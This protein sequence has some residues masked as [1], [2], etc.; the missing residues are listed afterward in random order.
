VKKVALVMV[1][2]RCTNKTKRVD[3][4]QGMIDLMDDGVSKD[5]VAFSK[6]EVNTNID[7]WTRNH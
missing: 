3:M 2:E 4:L 5:D 6:L 7:C 1:D